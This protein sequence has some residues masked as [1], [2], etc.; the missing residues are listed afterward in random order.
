MFSVPEGRAA[1]QPLRLITFRP[2]I[3]APLAG[4]FVSLA[5][6]G[7]PASSVPVTRSGGG[8]RGRRPGAAARAGGGAAPP[9]PPPRGGGGGGVD[10]GV[11]RRAVA[12]RQLEE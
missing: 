10:P 4:A 11:V 7:S 6:I 9:P 1:N 12:R 8:L 2:P 3:E 5:T